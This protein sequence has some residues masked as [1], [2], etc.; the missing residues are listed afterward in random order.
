MDALSRSR[1]PAARAASGACPWS[2]W[3]FSL[4][5]RWWE[6]YCATSVCQPWHRPWPQPG[7]RDG[8]WGLTWR[9]TVA[10]PTGATT[11][12]RRIP[13]VGPGRFPSGEIPWRLFQPE[14]V[15]QAPAG[16][17]APGSGRRDG[18]V[19]FRA[20]AGGFWRAGSRRQHRSG[21]R[22]RPIHR[23]CSP[24]SP[25]GSAPSPGLVGGRALASSRPRCSSREKAMPMTVLA[26]LSDPEIL[27]K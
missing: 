11:T 4:L 2:S 17:A 27:G 1:V 9:R 20:G 5:R 21:S 6:G 25:L 10:V 23:R 26:F 3:R 18:S 12:E 24:R 13:A 22:G 19:V 14:P 15:S 16:S 8:C 7:R